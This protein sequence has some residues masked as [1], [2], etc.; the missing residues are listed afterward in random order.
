MK[1][2]PK[3]NTMVMPESNKTTFKTAKGG[4]S[5]K[6]TQTKLFD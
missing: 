1:L 3:A 6:P 5:K 4:K 2:L